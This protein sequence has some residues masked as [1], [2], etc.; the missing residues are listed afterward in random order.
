MSRDHGVGAQQIADR[1]V[2]VAGG[3]FGG[4]NSI[5]DAEVSASEPAQRLPD[6]FERGV[7]LGLVDQAGAG[8]RAGIDH[9]IE[10]VVLGVEADRVEGIARGFDA[11]GAF[12][13]RRTQRVQR[14][15]EH[16]GF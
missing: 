4:I 8:D 7:A 1:A 15:R 12:D 10:G 3:A 9:G 6:I 14:E 5:I 13:P 2:A 16:E 11:D